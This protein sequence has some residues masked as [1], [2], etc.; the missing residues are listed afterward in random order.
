M[1]V[2]LLMFVAFFL[3]VAACT[4]VMHPE[5]WDPTVYCKTIQPPPDS[6]CI[7]HGHSK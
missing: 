5:K 6:W 2:T 3:F 4:P 7:Q 1:K